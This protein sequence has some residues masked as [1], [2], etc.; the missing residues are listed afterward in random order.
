MGAARSRFFCFPSVMV[1][2]L[3][4]VGA[5]PAGCAAAA[6]AARRGLRVALVERH[7]IPRHKTCG[8]GVPA[9]VQRYFDGLD[10][11]RLADVEVRQVR[12]TWRH[13]EGLTA[14]L[15]PQNEPPKL[16]CVRR[17]RFDAGLAEFAASCGANLMDGVTVREVEIADGRIEARGDMRAG[18]GEWRAAADFLIGADGA[19]GPVARKVGLA[20]RRASAMAMEVEVP[21]DWSRCS[22]EVEAST[23]YLEYGTVRH[24]Y[25]W[26]FP[27]SDHLN[28]GAGLFREA[29]G[30]RGSDL[31]A[32][33]SEAVADI[34]SA[35]G[36][37]TDTGDPCKHFHPVPLWNGRCRLHDRSGRVLLAGDAAA[38]VNPLFGDGILNAVHAG[39][40]AAEA[41]AA[42]RTLHYSNDVYAEIGRD[43]DAAGRI[44]RLFYAVPE[45]CFRIGVMRPTASLT[46]GKLLCGE[47]RYRD[48]S[49]RALRRI[50]AAMRTA[51][52]APGSVRASSQR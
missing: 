49:S 51:L 28:I 52:T 14:P 22:G 13:S 31:S 40:L 12:H 9:T 38:L 8:G 2:D 16:L 39:V 10:I 15:G 21:Y 27:K 23:I 1:Y 30:A 37:P 26:A 4:V 7:R 20:I 50:G 45:L 19:T 3:L 48:V 34:G 36:V 17:D 46:A 5:G 47:M 32:M 41:V 42:G 25:A 24:G 29:I 18:S 11:A 6:T 33:L 43:L 35:L 44:A